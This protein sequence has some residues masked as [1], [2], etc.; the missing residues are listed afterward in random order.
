PGIGPVWEAA[1]LNAAKDGV[2]FILADQKRIVLRIE[3]FIRGNKIETHPIGRSHH[4]KMI[5]GFGWGQAQNFSQ[6]V[7]GLMLIA[8][9]D[10]GMVQFNAHH[11]PRWI[12]LR[13]SAE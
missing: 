1:L 13:V 6:E 9:V 7:G 5:K 4:L 8:G 2:K 10:Y 11:S 3:L 12:K